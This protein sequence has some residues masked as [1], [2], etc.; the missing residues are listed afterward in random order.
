MPATENSQADPTAL[1]VGGAGRAIAAG[2]LT[3]AALTEALL[4]RIDAREPAVHA[5]AWLDPDAALAQARERDRQIT[6]GPLHGVPIGIKDLIDTADMPT[7]YGSPIH[8]NNRPADDGACVARLREAGAVILGKTTTTEFAFRHPTATRNPH[9]LDYTPGGSSSGSAAAVADS[10]VPA[11]LGTQTGGSIIRPSAFCGIVG[12]KPLFGVVPTAGLRHVAPSIDT[13]G[14]HIRSLDDIPM[15]TAVFTGAEMVLPSAARGPRIALCRTPYWDQADAAA[16]ELLEQTAD[17]LR[18]Q[19]SDVREV[20]LPTS[21]GGIEDAFHP[22]CNS[23]TLISLAPE[24]RDHR[25][26][27]S[28]SLQQI[29]AAADRFSTTEV[30]DARELIRQCQAEIGDM[31]GADETILTLSAPG[32]AVPD[33]ND[34]GNGI[35]NRLWTILDLPCLHLPISS[36]PNGMPLGVQLVSPRRDEAR[37]VVTGKWVAQRLQLPVLG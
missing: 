30:S 14:F 34:I 21:F 31:F 37:L 17:D 19:G 27:L 20:D 24:W 5:W 16:Q 7:S 6:R 36:G 22:I 29:L 8:R 4:A 13:I 18:S 33:L 23:E 10:M 32:E 26:E 3:S 35:F 15:L 28:E 1:S 9:H 25:S 11:A 2:R 12:Y